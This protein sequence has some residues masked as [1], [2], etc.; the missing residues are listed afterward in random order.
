MNWDEFT[1]QWRELRSQTVATATQATDSGLRK[2]KLLFAKLQSR[3][4]EL[5]DDAGKKI[6]GWTKSSSPKPS[7]K[8]NNQKV[9]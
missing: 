9:E 1:R 2:E 3:Y 7:S 5:V 8:S 4:G 6:E